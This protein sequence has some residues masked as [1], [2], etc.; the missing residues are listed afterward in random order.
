[1]TIY[2]IF[3]Y[4]FYRGK[5]QNWHF[6]LHTQ[7][8]TNTQ[9]TSK[10]SWLRFNHFYPYVWQQGQNPGRKI[11]RG[12]LERYF[13]SLMRILYPYIGGW[14]CSSYVIW[15]T[16]DQGKETLF[17]NIQNTGRWN[18]S[19]FGSRQVPT[20]WL[21]SYVLILLHSCR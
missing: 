6:L 10:I 13:I 21:G 3:F 7:S 1:M 19:A 15:R 20:Y 17:R 2:C 18:Y 14:I 4:K 8:H 11:P 16:C 5:D 12:F 9:N